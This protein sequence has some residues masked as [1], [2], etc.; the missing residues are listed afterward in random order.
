MHLAVITQS[1][2]ELPIKFEKSGVILIVLPEVSIIFCVKI[3]RIRC[4]E[5]KSKGELRSIAGCGGCSKGKG[6]AS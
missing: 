5:S 2:L 3:E 4:L 1:L 6:D